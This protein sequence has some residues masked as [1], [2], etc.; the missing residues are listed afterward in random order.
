[1]A[2]AIDTHTHFVPRNVPAAVGRN[3][4]WPSV[5]LRG[6]DGAAAVMVGGKVFRVIDSRSWDAAR[7]IDDMAA[8]DVD[9]QV[10]SPMPELLSHW[11][12][13]DDADAL[14]RHIN[15]GIAEL[16]GSQRGRFIGI[17]MLPM[18]D[19]GLAVKRLDELKSWGLRGFEIG[20][21][22]N[23][24]A[25]GDERLHDVYAAAEQANLAVMVHPLHPAG[26]DRM[27]GRPELAAVAAFPLE[28]AFA[29]V[30]L[31]TN[32]VMERFPRLRI[33]LSHGG[34]AL[35]WILPRLRHAR[36]IGPPLDSLFSRDP[37]E[38][39]KAFYF[40]SILYDKPALEFLANKVGRERVLVG[41][42]YPFTIKQDRPAEFAERSLA[43]PRQDLTA[44]ARRW[45]GLDG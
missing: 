42:D 8:D 27:G 23:G 25:L 41:S 2:E 36:G 20:T 18:Q 13:A 10:V 26:L 34:G 39:V 3:P 19:T 22:I 21:H 1:M 43:M 24:V 44:N 6:D 38:T 5:E 33:M 17:G 28:T 14:G 31:M 32:G 11:F 35:P 16:C 30:S 29:A 7:R 45:L 37:E 4:L 15:Q 12:P 40:D 9:V